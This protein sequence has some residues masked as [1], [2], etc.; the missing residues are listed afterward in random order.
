MNLARVNEILKNLTKG[1]LSFAVLSFTHHA[2]AQVDSASSAFLGS[3]SSRSPIESGLDSGRYKVNERKFQKDFTPQEFRENQVREQLESKNSNNGGAVETKNKNQ[4]A[5]GLDST[6]TETVK[7]PRKS[8]SAEISKTNKSSKGTVPNSTQNSSANIPGTTNPPGNDRQVSQQAVVCLP[9]CPVEANASTANESDS[10]ELDPNLDWSLPLLELEISM[11]YQYQHFESNSW[12]RSF[13]VDSPAFRASPKLWLTPEWG[14]SFSF[15]KTLA[16]TVSDSLDRSKQIAVESQWLEFDLRYRQTIKRNNKIILEY[17]VGVFDSQVTPDTESKTRLGLRSNGF[18]LLI[19]VQAEETKY[20]K[21][22]LT[23]IVRPSIQQHERN[24]GGK[25]LSGTFDQGSAFQIGAGESF[26]V[27]EEFWL[28]YKLSVLFEKA[29]YTGESESV[30]LNK[31][32]KLNGVNASNTSA[33]LE[34][35]LK[36]GK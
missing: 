34:I 31:G 11:L 18:Q 4:R 24:I 36:W 8:T 21:L 22:L 16:A 26:K 14:F 6:K 29:R 33:F 1:L 10:Y 25:Y 20:R 7:E 32:V 12:A 2:F 13:E 30:D 27:N 3:G 5:Y 35:G 19:D 23:T 9:A 28:F 17:G 15:A